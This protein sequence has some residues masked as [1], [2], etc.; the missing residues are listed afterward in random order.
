MKTDRLTHALL[1]IA[2][3]LLL[4]NGICAFEQNL[5]MLFISSILVIKW[6]LC[7]ICSH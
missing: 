1:F 4:I 2:G 6:Y 7:N 5:T 3:L